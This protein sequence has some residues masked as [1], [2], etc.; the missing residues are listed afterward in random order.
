[1]SSKIRKQ[2]R[3]I[4]HDNLYMYIKVDNNALKINFDGLCKYL[5]EKENRSFNPLQ[6]EQLLQNEFNQK[7]IGQP[8]NGDTLTNICNYIDQLS[9]YLNKK[10]LEAEKIPISDKIKKFYREHEEDYL[11]KLREAEIRNPREYKA[12]RSKF[13]KRR[14]GFKS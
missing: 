14:D 8:I 4:P 7:L 12:L 1:M 6:F 2:T 11:K 13:E 5:M 10:S 3:V 9:S